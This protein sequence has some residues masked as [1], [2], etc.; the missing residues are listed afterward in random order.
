MADRWFETS[1]WQLGNGRWVP[2]AQIFQRGPE[3]I[4]QT[5]VTPSNDADFETQQEARGISA[6]IAHKWMAEH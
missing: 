6:A 5:R 1:E 4:T 2:E 3:R